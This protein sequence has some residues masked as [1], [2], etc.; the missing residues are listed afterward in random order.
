MK[1]TIQDKKG[2]RVYRNTNCKVIKSY[3]NK[4]GVECIRVIPLDNTSPRNFKIKDYRF[5]YF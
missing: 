4:N 5:F 2:N 1:I 3:K